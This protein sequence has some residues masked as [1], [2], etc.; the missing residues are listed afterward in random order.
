MNQPTPL[1]D[2]VAI[3][4]GASRGIGAAIARKLASLAAHV[5]L[6]VRDKNRLDAIAAEII[7][8]GGH[9]ESHACDLTQ[10]EQIEAFARLLLEAHGRCDILV[11]N[12]G[13]GWLQGPLQETPL[14]VWEQQVALNLRAPY[15]M[16][17][18]FAPAMIAARRGHIINISSLAGRNPVPNGAAYA[19]TKWGLNGMMASAGEEL[20]PYQVRVS[21]VAPGTVRTEFGSGQSGHKS[22]LGAI[23]PDDIANIVALLATQADQS[24]I[25]EVQIRPTLKK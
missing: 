17:R 24:F 10:P 8:A 1:S 5:V 19:A 6:T 20:R 18:A 16:L 15:L 3:I 21:L 22:E 2:Q 11:K 7:N 4:T 14:E 13:I 9:A 23:A 12:A 25:S